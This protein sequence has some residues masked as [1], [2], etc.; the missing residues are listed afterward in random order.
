M[1]TIILFVIFFKC[2]IMK[3]IYIYINID[4]SEKLKLICQCY[5]NSNI[6]HYLHLK[7]TIILKYLKKKY[8]LIIIL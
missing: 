5:C 4:F 1:N 7:T 2:I 8:I 6:T 3:T